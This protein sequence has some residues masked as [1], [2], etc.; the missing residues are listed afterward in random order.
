[1]SIGDNKAVVGRWF[2]EYWGKDFSPAVID[3]LAAESFG[4]PAWSSHYQP[5]PADPCGGAPE[6][7]RDLAL[8]GSGQE[9][10]SE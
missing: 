10:P 8:S 5:R 7:G 3:E 6:L 9:G 2:T 4:R 1:M